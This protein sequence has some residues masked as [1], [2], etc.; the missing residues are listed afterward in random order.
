MRA[1][2]LM[3]NPGELIPAGMN[4][5]VMIEVEQ[6]GGLVSV[7]T[8]TLITRQGRQMVAVVDDQSK[9]QLR[10][11]AI[12]RDF[13]ERVSIASGL[14]VR[15]RVI[16]SP[17]ALLRPGDEVQIAASPVKAAAAKP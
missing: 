2:L 1:E 11:V 4:G 16:V 10:P 3:P 5:Q 13:G 17:N 12:A 8:N 15:D 7:P 14:T 9:F 6:S